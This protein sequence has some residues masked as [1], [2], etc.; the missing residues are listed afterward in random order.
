VVLCSRGLVAE[1]G[2]CHWGMEEGGC[3]RHY[4]SGRLCVKSQCI[5]GYFNNFASYHIHILNYI[6]HGQPFLKC[7][8][9]FSQ[10]TCVSPVSNS[11]TCAHF[12]SL[13]LRSFRHRLNGQPSSQNSRLQRITI[14]AYPINSCYAFLFINTVDSNN[15][16]TIHHIQRRYVHSHQIGLNPYYYLNRLSRILPQSQPPDQ[17]PPHF[18]SLCP[19]STYPPCAYHF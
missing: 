12:R 2:S 9:H 13:R 3:G 16:I 18:R 11:A 17:L 19:S 14:N 5:A 6:M 4:L 10:T 8:R 15:P 7:D 1:E